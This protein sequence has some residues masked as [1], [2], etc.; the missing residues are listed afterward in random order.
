MSGSNDIQHV[1][2]LDIPGISM[3]PIVQTALALSCGCKIVRFLPRTRT[4]IP[5][6]ILRLHKLRRE[7]LPL[8]LTILV[9]T[10]ECKMVMSKL[11]YIIKTQD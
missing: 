5:G 8:T 6:V 7:P 11:L 2:S 10:T 4:L 3:D 9:T 1:W